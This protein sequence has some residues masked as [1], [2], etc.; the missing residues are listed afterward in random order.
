M[1]NG[2]VKYDEY[3]DIHKEI[4]YNSRIQIYS[5]KPHFHKCFN[6]LRDTNILSN[7][8]NVQ[9]AQMNLYINKINMTYISHKSPSIIKSALLLVIANDISMLCA[10]A[11]ASLSQER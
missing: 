5:T 1:I 10:S 3:Y 4:I 9:D 8:R 2:H 7:S 11:V 6:C